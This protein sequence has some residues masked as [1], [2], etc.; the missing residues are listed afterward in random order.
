MAKVTGLGGVFFRSDDPAAMRQWYREHLGI[1]SEEYGF[2]FLWRELERPDKRGYTVWSPF[3]TASTYFEPSSKQFMVNYRVDDLAEL[4]R[5]FEEAGVDIAGEM[6]EEENGKF[7]WIL[8]PEGNKI[9]LWE[10]VDSDQD[11]YLPQP[12]PAAQ[13][14]EE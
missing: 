6:V 2:P 3:S 10:P 5:R 7:A 4:M 1:E 14:E 8:D 11:P 12:D 13:S 9:E